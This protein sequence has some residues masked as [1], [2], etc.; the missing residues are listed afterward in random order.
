MDFDW[1]IQG[2]PVMYPLLACSLLAVTIMIERT[3]FWARLRRNRDAALLERVCELVSR[4]EYDQAKAMSLGS[5]D[6]IVRIM[7]FGLTHLNVSLEAALRMAVGQEIR[8]MRKFLRV[9]DTI[10]TLAPL[11]GILG[12]VIGIITSFDV[13]SGGRIDNPVEVTGGIA[14][15]LLTTAFG[16]VIAMLALL[17]YNYFTARLEDA[18]S[19]MEGHLTSFEIMFEKGRLAGEA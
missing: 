15:A 18:I 9:L 13:M 6:P 17:P 11:L 16:L 14:Q 10:V 4:G 19:E 5:A 3:I 8:R 1:L 7:Q 2:G 12:T